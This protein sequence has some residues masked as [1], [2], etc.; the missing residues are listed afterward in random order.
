MMCFVFPWQVLG[1]N[2]HEAQ[3]LT[4][5]H[6]KLKAEING[7]QPQIDKTLAKGKRLCEEHHPE[8]ALVRLRVL[9][10]EAFFY[11]TSSAVQTLAQHR[12]LMN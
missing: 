8:A 11:N 5:K 7:H 3:T 10:Y 9:L 4:K 2:L 12:D 6:I 1:Q